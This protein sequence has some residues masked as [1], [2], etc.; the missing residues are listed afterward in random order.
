MKNL[1]QNLI[2]TS[3]IRIK[4]AKKFH[5]VDLKLKVSYVQQCMFINNSIYNSS[6]ADPTLTTVMKFQI[7]T[8]R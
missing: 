7:G 5:T 8:G 6:N 3:F 2:T 1:K 4:E